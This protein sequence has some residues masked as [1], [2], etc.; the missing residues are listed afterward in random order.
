M[1]RLPALSLTS[2]LVSGTIRM[3]LFALIAL[4]Q[5]VFWLFLFGNLFGPLLAAGKADVSTTAYQAMLVPGLTIMAAYFSSAYAGMYTLQDAD[6]GMLARQMAAPV[7]RNSILLAYVLHA[8]L[9]VVAQS[10]LLLGVAAL[11]DFGSN[12]PGAAFMYTVG[13]AALTAFAFASLSI[14][15]ALLAGRPEPVIGIMNFIALPMLF[16]SQALTGAAPTHPTMAM[17]AQF[18]PVNWAVMIARDGYLRGSGDVMAV[19]KLLI[20]ALV[21]F[22]LAMYSYRRYGRRL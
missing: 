3:P 9:L 8:A 20:F 17:L 14:A 2:R 19:A 5:P 1:K 6:S 15:L 12:Q 11:C 10:T 18:N 21:A 4:I 16:L 22:T 13:A 7:S